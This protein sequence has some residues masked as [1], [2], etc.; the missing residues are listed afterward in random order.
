MLTLILKTFK[1]LP[2]PCKVYIRLKLTV[3]LNVSDVTCVQSLPKLC[4]GSR[5][6]KLSQWQ[7]DV[8]LPLLRTSWLLVSYS[9]K[10][11][12]LSTNPDVYAW[13]HFLL[14]LATNDALRAHSQFNKIEASQPR[15]LQS[16]SSP[17]QELPISLSDE[18]NRLNHLIY[19]LQTRRTTLI[20]QENAQH[21]AIFR[22]PSEILAEIFVYTVDK[23]SGCSFNTTVRRRHIFTPIRLCAVCSHWRHVG[24]GSS[25]FRPYRCRVPIT[26]TWK[27]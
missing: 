10:Q 21:S 7:I 19:R 20:Q 24:Y 11:W 18:L 26:I 5:R 9:S 14:L 25:I 27:P 13:Y 4:G 2:S 8:T 12:T 6:P 23:S 22:L 17:T 15:K 3:F 1:Q 16:D